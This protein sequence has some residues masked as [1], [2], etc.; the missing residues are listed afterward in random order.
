LR[1]SNWPA[2]GKGADSQVRRKAVSS[3][4]AIVLERRIFTR[5]TYLEDDEIVR[6]SI[7][8]T[9]NP[10]QLFFSAGGLAYV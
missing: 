5:K 2:Y 4:I 3:V 8:S 7:F 9:I 10:V 6:F 1:L